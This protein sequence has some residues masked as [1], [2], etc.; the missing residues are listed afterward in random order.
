MKKYIIFIITSIMLSCSTSM[1]QHN[2]NEI[3]NARNYWKGK[4]ENT[5]LMSWGAPYSKSS[6]GSGGKIHTYRRYNGYITWVTDFYINRDS[7]IYHLN[8]HSE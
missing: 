1:Q 2:S 6:D 8:A 3:E 7:I 4:T 5:L